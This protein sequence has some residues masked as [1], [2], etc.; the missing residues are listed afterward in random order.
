[1]CGSWLKNSLQ[2]PPLW[3][4]TATG[5]KFTVR[6][7]ELLHQGHRGHHHHEHHLHCHMPRSFMVAPAAVAAGLQVLLLPPLLLVF[8]ASCCP[9][10]AKSTLACGCQ[11]L[12]LQLWALRRHKAIFMQPDRPIL[13]SWP[14]P[15]IVNDHVLE[16][17]PPCHCMLW[18]SK[19][20]RN[21]AGGTCMMPIS[22]TQRK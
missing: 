1:M 13:L 20:R 4:A 8:M 5:G 10:C 9:L 19:R 18:A 22:Q 15:R 12:C 14:R 7:Y 6:K 2:L 3:D 16:E 17:T 11:R 21:S